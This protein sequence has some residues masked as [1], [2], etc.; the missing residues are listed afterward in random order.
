MIERWRWD[1]KTKTLVPRSEWNGIENKPNLQIRTDEIPPTESYATEERRVFTSLAKLRR[2]YKENGCV[3]AT[4]E[5]LKWKPKKKDEREYERQMVDDIQQ[6]FYDAKYDRMPVT[7][8]ERELW[9]QEK[10]M[11]QRYGK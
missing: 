3:E 1:S 8:K 4:G 7:E 5:D 2:H 10:K 11:Q 9:Q 6:S